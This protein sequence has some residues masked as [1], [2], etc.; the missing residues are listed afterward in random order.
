MRP[1]EELFGESA[2]R[3]SFP[4][5]SRWHAILDAEHNVIPAR[6]LLEWGRW[7]ENTENRRVAETS[8][9]GWWVSTVFLGLDHSFSSISGGPAKPLWFESMIFPEGDKPMVPELGGK[10]RKFLDGMQLRYTTWDEAV[11]G[12]ATLVEMIQRGLF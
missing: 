5:F 12:H 7:F 2:P 8:I 10:L 1:D 4:D 11:K 9:N 6:D 3:F